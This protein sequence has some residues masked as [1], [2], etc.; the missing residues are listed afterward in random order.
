[1]DMEL[2]ALQLFYT[3]NPWGWSDKVITRSAPLRSGPCK[4]K[5]KSMMED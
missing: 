4:R 2:L 3:V 1:M 5:P